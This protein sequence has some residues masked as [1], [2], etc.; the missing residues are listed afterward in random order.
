MK[1][2]SRMI[3]KAI[4]KRAFLSSEKAKQ[5]HVSLALFLVV[6][7]SLS[8]HSPMAHTATPCTHIRLL[9]R[10]T[11]ALGMYAIRLITAFV[12]T[13]LVIAVTGRIHQ[14]LHLIFTSR[15]YSREP[16]LQQDVIFSSA[17]CFS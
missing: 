6:R 1:I 16:D 11:V 8:E 2:S 10:S 3:P 13:F 15:T 7:Y 12:L 4:A 14:A 5:A 9:P 17:R